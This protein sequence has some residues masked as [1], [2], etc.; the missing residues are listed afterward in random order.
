MIRNVP[1]PIG[2]HASTCWVHFR[3]FLFGKIDRFMTRPP[4]R[5]KRSILRL[6]ALRTGLIA[7]LAACQTAPPLAPQ[8]APFTT[9]GCSMFPN[10]SPDGKTDWCQCCLAH[11]LAY[12][13]GGTA[14]KREQADDALRACVN[15]STDS[16]LLSRVMHA[17]VRTAGGPQ[18]PT[19]FRWGY[20]WPYGRNYLPLDAGEEAQVT[21]M[22]AAYLTENPGLTCGPTIN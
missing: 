10:R 1:A 15:A 16:P 4:H 8:L 6:R 11:D 21:R 19:S 5:S 3:L 2:G 22:R 17:G 12:W 14:A 20:G 13:R 18:L 9:D 7:C